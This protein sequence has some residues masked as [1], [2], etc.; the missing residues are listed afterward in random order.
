MAKAPVLKTGG[1]KP[2]Q[3]RILCP[4]SL[5]GTSPSH[6]FC[7]SRPSRSRLAF[8]IGSLAVAFPARGHAQTQYDSVFEQFKALAPTTS[9]ATVKGLVLRRDVMELRLDSGFAYLLTPVAGRTVG[10]AFIGGGSLSFEPPLAVEKYHLQRV[11]GDS[12]VNGPITAA[13]FLFADST[14]DEL[15]HRLAFSSAPTAR[16]G[17]VGDAVGDALDYL[18]DGRAHAVESDLFATI[19]NKTTTPFFAAYL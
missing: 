1:R 15:Q 10:I 11:F 12:T 7:M 8:V 2:L 13:V 14:G 9:R 19:L 3:V 18:V 16:S 4:P 6:R 5:Y 17:D